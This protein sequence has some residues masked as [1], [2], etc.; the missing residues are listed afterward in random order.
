MP[1]AVIS[2]SRVRNCAEDVRGNDCASWEWL[3]CDSLCG[4]MNSYAEGLLSGD[5]E[6]CSF[7]GIEIGTETACTTS[8]CWGYNPLHQALLIRFTTCGANTAQDSHRDA[9]RQQ[10]CT[11]AHR[12][13]V[14]RKLSMRVMTL[15][16]G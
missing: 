16:W 1:V 9:S 5:A 15:R 2:I 3:C 7:A 13:R 4:G 8:C 12:T 14:V 10:P 6:R 11:N